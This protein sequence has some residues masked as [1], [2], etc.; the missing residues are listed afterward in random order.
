MRHVLRLDRPLDALDLVLSPAN[1][2]T[3]PV[4]TSRVGVDGVQVGEDRR[5][6]LAG[7]E[8]RQVE[9]VRA[10][11]GDRTQRAALAGVEPPV[12]VGR[13]QQPVLDVDAVDAVDRA[14]V[15]ATH[16]RPRLPAER[17]E[18]DVVVRAVDEPAVL[19][20][21]QQLPDSSEVS[22]SGFSQ[23]TCFPAASTAFTCG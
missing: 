11:V 23:T 6:A 9:P 20:E 15:A 19:R 17:I 5:D 8:A 4:G 18:A 22:A 13:L 1:V 12:P 10:D 7:D 14:D 16:P 3:G 2:S 21:P